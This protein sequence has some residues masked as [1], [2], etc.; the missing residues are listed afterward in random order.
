M[1]N[2]Y[3]QSFSLTRLFRKKSEK[4]GATYFSGRLGNAR[5]VL[6]KSK[7]TADDGG[8][9][10]NLMVSEAPKRDNEA[11]QRQEP[12][13]TEPDRQQAARSSWQRPL[14]DD[15]IPFAPEWR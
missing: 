11:G 10:W 6:L 15:T 7:D 9:I 1:S 8:E 3:P 5:V 13:R 4:T 12:P 14:D 2:N